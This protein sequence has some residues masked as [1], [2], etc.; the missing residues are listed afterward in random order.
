MQRRLPV[1]SDLPLRPQ[2]ETECRRCDVHCDKVVYPAACVEGACP[3]LY[4]YEEHGR[5]F[6][7]C[8][9]KVYGVEID[10]ELLTRAQGAAS[11]FGAVKARRQPLPMC[12]AEVSTCYENRTGE[13]GCVNPEF[14]ELPEG[15]PSFRVTGGGAASD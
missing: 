7:G 14:L 13:L 10:L 3:F 6:V 4:A 12:R 9:Q 2:D 11:G 5:T 15:T 8:M 1:V